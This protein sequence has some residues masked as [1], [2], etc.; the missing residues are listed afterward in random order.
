[1]E[2]I[3]LTIQE[4][5]TGMKYTNQIRVAQALLQA[6][7]QSE[8]EF[9]EHLRATHSAPEGWAILDWTVGL[10]PPPEEHHAHG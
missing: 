1:M 2:P 8:R 3:T 10:V 4:I 9:I 7:E 6:A 5:T